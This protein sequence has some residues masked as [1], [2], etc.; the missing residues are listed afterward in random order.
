MRSFIFFTPPQILLGI[1]SR[2]WAGHAERMVKESR[3]EESVQG[4]GRKARRKEN[5]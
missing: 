2:K 1:K 4:F 5:T 3:G